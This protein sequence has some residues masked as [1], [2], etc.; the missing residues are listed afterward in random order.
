MAW[1]IAAYGVA[2]AVLAIAAACVFGIIRIC[3][4]LKRLETTVE[5]LSQESEASLKACRLLADE[6]QSM[7]SGARRSMAG[8][9][10]LSEGARALGEA[11]H[12]AARTGIAIYS[13]L[14]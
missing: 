2:T 1:E 6:A 3:R 4:T 11:A 5:R 13:L 8:F 12:Q 9:S 7:I 10:S 14:P